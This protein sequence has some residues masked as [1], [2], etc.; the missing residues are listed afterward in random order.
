LTSVACEF[1][2]A[3]GQ[4]AL[5]MGRD[6]CVGVTLIRISATVVNGALVA[7]FRVAELGGAVEWRSG[8]RFAWPAALPATLRERCC[9]GS[10][11][12]QNL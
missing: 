5:G 6:S 7:K 11:I 3:T 10:G 8:A 2:R 1:R 4:V 12:A 9:S